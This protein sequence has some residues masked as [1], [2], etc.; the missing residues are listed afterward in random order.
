M[1]SWKIA[2]AAV[3]NGARLAG[4]VIYAPGETIHG[5]A[6]FEPTT[7]IEQAIQADFALKWR[8]GSFAFRV[9]DASLPGPVKIA[10]QS[11]SLPQIAVGSQ[12]T[13]P[14]TFI[15][16]SDPWSYSGSLFSLIW[17]VS[18]DLPRKSW[19]DFPSAT[20]AFQMAPS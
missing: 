16:P 8:I 7:F 3:K 11:F 18:V 9:D 17:E 15:L 13:V 12:M 6:T 1:A 5:E 20:L 10:K 2:M 14:F 19:F 4:G